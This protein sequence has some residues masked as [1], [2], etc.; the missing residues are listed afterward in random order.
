VTRDPRQA[1]I[2]GLPPPAPPRPPDGLGAL[3]A[4]MFDL[5]G[6]LVDSEPLW[7]EAERTVMARLG[8]Q[9]GAAD[10]HALIGGSLD[11]TVSYLL[12]RAERRAGRGEVARW[13]LE[14]MTGLMLARGLPVQP[15]ARELVAEVAG[16]GLPYALVTSSARQIMRAALAVTGLRF[17]VTVCGEDV[18]RTKP[19]P[20]PY[21]LAAA[22]LGVPPPGC[23]ACED[24]PNGVAAARAAGCPVIAVPSVPI[25]PGPGVMTVESLA[26][27]NLSVLVEIAGR[28]PDGP[29]RAV[30]EKF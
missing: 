1:E 25:P 7:F 29:G 20:E 27:V 21:L 12:A 22:R 17:P 4:V 26:M 5:D 8:G 13:L 23:V 2:T 19:D 14:G 15:G 16:A 9:W 28:K 30:T 3:R 11:R 24:S 6:L 18:G 10:Q